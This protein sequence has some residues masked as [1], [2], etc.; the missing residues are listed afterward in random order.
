MLVIPSTQ[1]I[2]IRHDAIESWSSATN[3]EYPV[4]DA[5]VFPELKAG[6][7]IRAVVFVQNPSYWLGEIEIV[8]AKGGGRR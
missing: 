7:Q 2:V 3:M 8:S 1:R 5:T 4:R 6:D